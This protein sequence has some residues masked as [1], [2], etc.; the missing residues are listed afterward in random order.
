MPPAAET[1][2]LS[3]FLE[4]DDG[5]SGVEPVSFGVGRR[6]RAA[7]LF[8]VHY[9]IDDLSSAINVDQSIIIA[10]SENPE[11]D[12]V[13]PATLEIA[14]RDKALY[15][16]YELSRRHGIVTTGGGD[17]RT[18]TKIIPL[19]GILVPFRQRIIVVNELDDTMEIRAEIYYEPVLL[20]E[21]DLESINRQHGA[22]RRT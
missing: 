21:T 9:S 14:R 7:R 8:G 20:P 13:P 5:A 16:F 19:Y 4:V 22:Y 10:L 15:G 18:T 12:V 1:R 3:A 2:V 11:H 17:F 6:D